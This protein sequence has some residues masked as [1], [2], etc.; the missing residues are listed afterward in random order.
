MRIPLLALMIAALLLPGC[1]RLREA[2][3]NPFNWF[4][5]SEA[6]TLEPSGGYTNI[7]DN[8]ALVD[9]VLTLVI[10]PMPGGA[11]VRA[12][13]LPPTQGFWQ[14]ELVAE[15]DGAPVDG[16]LTL[17]FVIYPPPKTAAV[18]TQASREI[19][20]GY[21]LSNIALAKITRINV[22]GQST[23]LSVRR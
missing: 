4:K 16:V 2:R 5:T 13:G 23:A 1:A 19:T 9:Q 12:R 14:A 10:D 7:A 18:S 8:R 20:V 3:I 6:A 21:Y 15:N 11:I 17:R 22:Q